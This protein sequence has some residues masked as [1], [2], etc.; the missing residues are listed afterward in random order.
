MTTKYSTRILSIL[1][2]G[3]SILSGFAQ[4]ARI[5][6]VHNA[7]NAPA[8]DVFVNAT[9]ILSNVSFRSAS[10]F[11]NATAGIPLQVRIKPTSASNDTSNPVFFKTYTLE[12][13]KG[14]YLV[15]NGNLAPGSMAPNPTGINTGFDITVIPDAKETADNP[16]NVELRIMHSA[17]DA[18]TVD[19]KAQGVATLV[20]DAAFRDFTGYIPVPAANY[21]VQI[22]PASG[23][24][25]LFAYAA[26]LTGLAG[27]TALVLA[28][29]Y[30]N[31]AANLV[32]G[33]P[34]PSFG[35]FAF[36]PTGN[37]IALPTA[38]S[39]V[40]VVHNC[41]NAPSVDIFV[42]G[43]KGISGL[44]FRKATPFIDLNAGVPLTISIKGASAS[45]DTSNPAFRKTYELIGGES[46]TLVATG[47]LT[48][49]GYA[50]NPEGRPVGFDITV[51]PGAKEVSSQ[52]GSAELRV[53]HGATDAPKVDVRI[54]GG[55]VI[56]NNAGFRDFSGYL[57]AG[58]QNFNV[59]ITD[60]TNAVV[61]ATFLAP[62]SGFSDSALV[63][64]ASGFLSPENNQNGAPFGLLAVTP[65]GQAILLP[66]VTSVKK[67][68]ET[69]AF[70][71]FPNPSNGTFFTV[72][73]D[74]FKAEK[75]YAISAS[76]QKI[77]LQKLS[78]GK[79]QHWSSNLATGLYQIQLVSENGI[80]KTGRILIN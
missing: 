37:A 30:L 2:W 74:G 59:E 61:V 51:M 66:V 45:S 50:A 34:G 65:K 67:V 71:L 38:T 21:T 10:S 40:Q 27:N 32:N 73:E 9:K 70:Q 58:N 11:Q 72:F 64:M 55:S 25:N 47:L 16:N 17:T 48:T 56:V 14:Y 6:V 31:P 1:L 41:A 15:A 52:P 46:Y 4:N 19:I 62:V 7:A 35:V 77:A 33:Q 76:G 79:N 42:N 54:Q 22:S 57:T 24:P 12:A 68:N 60:S 28:S 26:P 78:E 18:P 29:G 43:A 69:A 3:I 44:D 13:N 39:R 5:Q 80:V 20:N 8:V 63:V 75:G 23:N 36:T 53:L 49:T